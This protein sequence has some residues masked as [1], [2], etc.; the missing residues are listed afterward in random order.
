MNKMH[1]CI[2]DGV[3]WKFITLLSVSFTLL[4]SL[5]KCIVKLQPERVN[6]QRPTLNTII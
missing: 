3:N 4:R 5:E 2:Y 1:L 6:F